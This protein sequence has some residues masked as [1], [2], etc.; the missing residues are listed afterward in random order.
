M[1]VSEL[2]VGFIGLGSQ[3]GPMA[4]A[5]L[6][7]GYDLVVWARRD[8]TL[9]PYRGRARIVSS[10]ADLAERSDIVLLCVLKDEDVKDV[11]LREDGVLA[12]AR[13]GTILVVHSTTHPTTCV[14]LETRC[15]EVGVHLLDAPVSGG[16]AAATEHRLL[17]MVG[18]NEVT[19]RR[20]LP[21]LSI[22]GEP[23]VHLGP[24]GAG[25]TA[26]L[27]NN[28]LFTANIGVAHDSVSLGSAFG[29][30][31]EALV[32][33]LRHGSSRSYAL[34]LY[35]GMRGGITDPSRTGPIA[36]LLG[37]DVALAR[38]L[39]AQLGLDTNSIFGTADRILGVMGSPPTNV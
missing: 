28:V 22:F 15:R 13:A 32:Q 12:G 27:V 33:V 11:V 38:L 31:A 2:V 1:T 14:D 23:V 24:V 19:F 36:S 39:A 17:V 34:D 20:V 35:S 7:A 21:V 4:A 6:D 25:Q 8:Q 30:D 3:G 37:K 16:G 9:D 10:P 26:K 29:L 5:V 18:G